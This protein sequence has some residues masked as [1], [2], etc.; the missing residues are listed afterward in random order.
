MRWSAA[1]SASRE[2]AP[3]LFARPGPLDHSSAAEIPY[4]YLLVVA[5]KR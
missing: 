2:V 4:E 1:A 3:P 5:R